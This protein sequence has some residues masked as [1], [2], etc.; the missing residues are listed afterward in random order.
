M[1]RRMALAVGLVSSSAPQ[2]IPPDRLP[3]ICLAISAETIGEMLLKAERVARDNPLL[4]LRLDY[5]K[6]PLTAPARIRDFI[7]VHPDT[8][9][10]A[11]CRKQLYGG[12]F[13]GSC[14]AEISLLD[15][16]A[17]AGC[18]LV[19]VSLQ[20]AEH[21]SAKSLDHLRAQATLILSY[22]DFKNTRKL[23]DVYER[24][25]AFPADIFKIATTAHSFGDNV[26]LISFLQQAAAQAAVVGVCMGEFGFPSRLLSLRAGGLFTFASYAAGEETAPGQLDLRSLRRVYRAESVNRATKV[27]GVLGYPL[28]HSLSPLMMNAALR[29]ESVNAVYLPLLARDPADILKHAHTM[30]LSGFSVTQPHKSALFA[31]L[32]GV[33]PLAKQ[34]GAVNTVVRSNGKLYG[35]NT[36]IGAIVDPLA[37]QLPLTKAKILLLGA[38]GAAR[39][40]AFG[41]RSRGADVF[42][43]NRTPARAQKLA[44]QAK[45]KVVRRT[46]LK[47]L[48]FDAI[49]NATPVGQF[50]HVQHSP[51]EPEEIR[52]RIAF[53]L[54]YNPMETR[55]LQH[56]RAQGCKL[57]A[58]LEM[59]VLQGARQFE[60]WT[61][62]PAPLE[63][64][65]REV[66]THLLTTADV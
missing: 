14:D 7:D 19:D 51:L 46:D 3:R 59:F 20:T 55:F 2:R 42:I 8:I 48:Q 16:A 29:R 23:A 15:K 60:I 26:T 41:L 18:H 24:M 64:M 27:Y 12:K 62:K 50:P 53:D 10:I 49:I 58:G 17:Q 61:G 11:T 34:A 43:Y 35:F 63:E 4:E 37:A 65:R 6:A 1:P 21:V 40:A 28:G 38:G 33:D 9:L 32:D 31:H 45:A 30:P 52:A 13:K 5:L 25:R 54:V 56:A 39:A 44:Q 66:I 47:K 36:D 22:H 57:I